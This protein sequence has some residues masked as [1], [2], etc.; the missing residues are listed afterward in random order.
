MESLKFYAVLSDHICCSDSYP[1]ESVSVN[2]SIVSTSELPQSQRILVIDD[3]ERIHQDFQCVLKPRN[4]DDADLSNLE[5]AFTGEA[6][7]T[8]SPMCFEV[9]CALTGL[10]GL[11]KMKAASSEGRPYALA[12]VDLRLGTGWDGLA[13]IRAL[14]REDQHL[15]VVICT[16]YTDETLEQADEILGSSDRCLILKKPY[17]PIEVRQLTRAMIAKWKLAKQAEHANHM[18]ELTVMDL[19]ESNRDLERFG[20]IASHHLQEPLRT[21]SLQCELLKR[22]CAGR[23]G[24]EVDE[25]ANRAVADAASARELVLNLLTYSQIH[26]PKAPFVP[27]NLDGLVREVVDDLGGTL[28]GVDAQFEI[29]TLPEVIG[30]HEQLRMVFANL[31]ENAIKYRVGDAVCI[32]ITSRQIEGA[33]EFAVADDGIGIAKQYHDSVFNLF[34]RL[35]SADAYPGTGVG[36]SLCKKVLMRHQGKIWL[37]SSPDNGATFYFTLPDQELVMRPDRIH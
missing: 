14:W 6:R 37:D 31:V 33:W 1:S 5:S 20:Y 7:T 28:D 15:Q 17:D 21:I 35:H 11:E 32:A 36:L 8:P 9:D 10:E 19:M 22:R 12:F 25:I 26:E 16:A 4:M 34:E 13:T 29:D 30:D 27:V 2:G 18:L 23:L 3:E 24:S